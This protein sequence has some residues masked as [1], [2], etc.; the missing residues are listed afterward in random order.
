AT[1]AAA[2]RAGSTRDYRVDGDPPAHPAR[3]GASPRLYYH[4]GELVTHDQ[5]RPPVG[6]PAH[7][8][9]DLRTADAGSF[10]PDRDPVRSRLRPSPFVPT[11]LVRPPPHHPSPTQHCP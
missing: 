8:T 10:G 2:K 4:A 1:A 7:I 6:L 5:G 9:L 3:V 11:H